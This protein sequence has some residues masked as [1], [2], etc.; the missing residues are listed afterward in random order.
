VVGTLSTSPGSATRYQL[1]NGDGADDNAKFAI[2]GDK[3]RVRHAVT[4]PEG[5][6]YSIRVRAFDATGAFADEV[7]TVTVGA[8]PLV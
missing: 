6:V 3:L 4:D 1:V 2:S 8:P 7:L 5:T